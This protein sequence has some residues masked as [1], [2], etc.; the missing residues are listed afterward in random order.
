MFEGFSRE[1][2]EF[3]LGIRL[4]NNKEWFEPRK[5]IYVEK[6]YEP[7]KALGDELFAPFSETEGMMKNNIMYRLVKGFGWVSMK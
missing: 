1:A 4:N 3:L 5:Q 7:M 2:L 6:I